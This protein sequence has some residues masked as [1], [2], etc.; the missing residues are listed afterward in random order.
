MTSLLTRQGVVVGYCTLPRERDGGFA[1]FVAGI[2]NRIRDCGRE[3]TTVTAV[4]EYRTEAQRAEQEVGGCL[5]RRIAAARVPQIAPTWE[6]LCGGSLRQFAVAAAA[7]GLMWANTL[8]RFQLGKARTS[9]EGPSSWIRESRV[10]SAQEIWP[11]CHF[12]NASA[13]AVM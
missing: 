8:R 1:A 7:S 9:H 4:A 5:G 6:W 3:V 2:R 10:A 11:A 12:T 13:S